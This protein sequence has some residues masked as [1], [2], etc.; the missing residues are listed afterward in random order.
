MKK[1]SDFTSEQIQDAR[2]K[3]AN[4]FAANSRAIRAEDPYASHVTEIEKDL[5]LK[6]GLES[7]ERVR[8]GKS[9]G[10]FTVAQRIYFELTGEC[11][12]FL[13]KYSK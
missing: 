8:Q 3:V 9:D 2:E 1:F 6:E 10:N 13:P 5:Y 4:W 11:V 12:G 7:A